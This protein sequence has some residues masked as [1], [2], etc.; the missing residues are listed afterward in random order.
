M[1]RSG[2][3]LVGDV[4]WGTHFCQ[5]YQDRQDL[6]DILVSYFQHG[7]EDNEYCMW[8]TSQPLGVDEACVALRGAVPDLD[9]HIRRGQI[10]FLDYRQWYKVDGRFDADRVLAGW[11]QRERAALE[12]GFAGLRLTGNTFWLEKSDWRDFTDYEAVVDSVI[13]AHR[14]LALCTYSIAKCGAAEIL[15]VVRNHQFALM[16]QAGNWELIHS[17]R[18]EEKIRQ[19]NAVLEGMNRIFSEALTCQ[20]EEELGHVCLRVAE[21]VTG[22]KFGFIGE[23]NAEGRLED[24]ALSD[25]GWAACRMEVPTRHRAIP[26]GFGIHGICER[27]LADGKALL[28]NDPPAHPDSIG[29]PVGHPPLTAFLGAPLIHGGKTVGMVGVANRGGGYRAEDQTALQSV[30]AATVQVLMRRRGERA[31][32]ENR[33][34]L[35]VTLTSIGDAVIATDMEGRITFLNP[36]AEA[37]TAWTLE[38]SLGRPVASVF[39]TINEKTGQPAADVVS[40]ALNEKCVVNLANHTALVTRDGR[41]IP[42]EDSAAPILDAAGNVSGAVLVFHEVTEKRRAQELLRRV[43]EQRRLALQ[44]AD[45][46]TWDYHFDTGDV[47]WDERCREMFGA[48]AGSRIDYEGA[49][50]CVHPDYR[51]TVNEGVQAALAGVQDG[52][53][54]REFPVCWPDGSTHW[55]ASHGRVYFEGAGAQRRAVRFIGA[56]LDITQRR[57]EDQELRRLNRTLKAHSDSDQAMMRATDEPDYLREVCRIII[58]DCGHAMV[59]I[60]YAENDEGRTVR[61]AAYAGFDAGYINSLN[62]TWADTERG[63][64]PTGTAIRTGQPCICRNMLTDVRFEPWRAEARKRGYAASIAVPIVADG[65]ALGA[66]TIYCREPD[67]FSDQEVRLLCDLAD[68]LAYGITALRLR[69]AH[70]RAE[71]L[72]EAGRRSLERAKLELEQANAAKDRFIAALSHELRTPL[73]PVIAATGSLLLD[74]RMPQDIREDLEMVHR[75]VE[76]EVALIN[77]LL[78]VT[79]IISGKLVL[80][81]RLIDAV[82]VLREAANICSPD[83]VA[84]SQVLVVEVEAPGAPY[85]VEADS[86]RLHQVFW[87]LIKNAIKFTPARGK[88]TLRATTAES[89]LRVSVSDNGVGIDP[90]ALPRIFGAFEQAEQGQRFGGLGLGLAI[91]KGVVEAHG[92]RVSAHS[93]GRGAGATFTVELPLVCPTGGR[94][95]PAERRSE[96]VAPQSGKSLRILLVE[97]HGDTARIMTRLLKRSGHVV[98]ATADIRSALSHSEQQEFDLLISD[99]GLPDGNGLDLMSQLRARGWQAPGIALTG[100]GQEDDLRRTQEV[101]FTAHLTKPVDF[102]QL[103]RMIWQACTPQA[104]GSAARHTGSAAGS[105]AGQGSARA[106]GQ[107]R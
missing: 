95:I 61:P 92:G 28:T 100:Y 67:P 33:E 14:M 91:A 81:K 96:P 21:E 78:D 94:P 16:K 17:K 15:D 93:A 68:D 106:A 8:I 48:P 39:C 32:Q 31:L 63:R 35:R 55:I 107:G 30:A 23:I 90:A 73:T 86:A 101:G 85:V 71:A 65:R 9:D 53:Y 5:F 41:H 40:R 69:E 79:R 24:I 20:T 57:K 62:I 77:D 51:V 18:A 45:L 80:E 75:N 58:E 34:W 97:D 88:I 10:E 103:E 59:W 50:A 11:V 76:L 83:L 27:V 4:P 64:G 26:E 89:L 42:I 66:L 37:L 2:L 60:G 46:G 36:V 70:A 12:R 25:P 84:K 87:N 6:I 102:E 38:R 82:E 3:E 47:F 74:E 72:V 104:D 99:L 56:N 44:A 13:G 29:A 22:S 1:R 43:S 49:I 98:T 105:R 52:A 19:Q 7:L 54:H